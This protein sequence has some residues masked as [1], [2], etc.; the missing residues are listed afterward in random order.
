MQMRFA[1]AIGLIAC[2]GC[3]SGPYTYAP[4]GPAGTPPRQSDL[5]PVVLRYA[6]P[7]LAPIADHERVWRAVVDVTDDYFRIDREEPVRVYGNMVTEG[8]IETFPETG[9][10]LLEPWRKDAAD[11]YERLEGTLQSIRRRAALKVTPAGSGFLV[12][13]NVFKELEDVPRPEHATAGAATL[14]YDTSMTR[15]VNPV[16]EQALTPRLDSLGSRPGVGTADAGEPGIARRPADC[17]VEPAR[18]RSAVRHAGRMQFF[19][20][21][22]AV[23]LCDGSSTPP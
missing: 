4:V 17:P 3:S 15:I 20:P 2:A 8:R 18:R 23:A 12:E 7:S 11:S 16:G 5:P 10:T 21:S 22:P 19:L 9:A 13:I 1:V 14:R 6:N